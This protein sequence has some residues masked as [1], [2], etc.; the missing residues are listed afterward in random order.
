MKYPFIKDNS[1]GFS[2]ER[3]AAVLNVSR[4]GYYTWLDRPRSSRE[5]E[6]IRLD[7]EIKS[8]YERSQSRYGS[9]KIT[10]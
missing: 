10:P 3:M 8:V 5:I 2:V 1:S 4:S 9:V 7:V 6:N